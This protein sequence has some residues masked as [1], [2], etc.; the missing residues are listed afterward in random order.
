MMNFGGFRGAFN[1]GQQAPVTQ[2]RPAMQ[3]QARPP[4]QAR[5]A[6][7]QQQPQQSQQSQQQ[8]QPGMASRMGGAMGGMMAMSD[9][10]SKEEIK[11]LEGANDALS[12]ALNSKAEYPDT[13]APSSGMQALG[14]Q[15]SPPSH[16]SFPDAPAA[17]PAAQRVAA[18]NAAM[19]PAA[20]QAPTDQQAPQN[21]WGVDLRRPDLS[22]LDDAYANL[23]RG[24]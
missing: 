19:A 23:G 20:Q 24:G 13:R 2:Q 17:S 12:R 6:P 8:P 3:Q 10:H 18:Q 14:Q 22:E 4:M 11:R 16:A 5:P 21:P 15:S 7:Q 1:R 9:K